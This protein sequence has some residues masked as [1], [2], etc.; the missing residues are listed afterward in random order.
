[1]KKIFSKLQ[2]FYSA[3]YNRPPDDKV[4][5]AVYSAGFNWKVRF[6]YRRTLKN[7]HLHCYCP[8][9]KKIIINDPF[10]YCHTL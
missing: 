10:A 1:M 4:K 6:M 7:E 2:Q 3:R 5:R 8:E 9:G